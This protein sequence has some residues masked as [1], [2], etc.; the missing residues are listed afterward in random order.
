[1][2]A[3]DWMI[4]ATTSRYLYER[5]ERSLFDILLRAANSLAKCITGESRDIS[6]PSLLEPCMEVSTPRRGVRSVGIENR[7]EAVG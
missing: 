2:S 1:M 7:V 5:E 3:K 4:R 6:I